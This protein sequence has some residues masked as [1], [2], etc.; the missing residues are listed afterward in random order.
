MNSIGYDPRLIDGL[1]NDI[2]EGAR[3]TNVV[4]CIRLS[5][6]ELTNAIN[7]LEHDGLVTRLAN[8]RDGRRVLVEITDTGRTVAAAASDELN[9]EVFEAMPLPDDGLDVL[10]GILTSLRAGWGDLD[11]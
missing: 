3:P 4:L 5:G 1:F 9:A 6:D 10:S 7:R 2:H 11:G 8:P